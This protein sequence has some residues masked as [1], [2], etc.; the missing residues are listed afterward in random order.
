MKLTP[1]QIQQ[2]YESGH[3]CW[4]DKDLIQG[5]PT[6]SIRISFGYMSTMRDVNSF[7]DFTRKFFVEHTLP[8]IQQISQSTKIYEFKLS[9]FIIYPVKSAKGISVKSWTLGDEGPLY[10][11][12]WT[13]VNSQ[14]FAIQQKSIP[15]LGLIEPELNLET[16]QLI[17]RAPNEPTDLIISLNELPDLELS[18]QLTVC[19]HK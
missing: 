12:E 18:E 6:G 1:E 11:R 9:H 19:G 2:N 5:K 8:V 16:H 3:V 10:D 17:L 7:L 15:L 14:G 4:D 13:V